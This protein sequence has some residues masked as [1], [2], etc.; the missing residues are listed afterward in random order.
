MSG[1]IF[2]FTPKK[3]KPYKIVDNNYGYEQVAHH[4][5]TEHGTVVVERKIG[6]SKVMVS[7]TDPTVEHGKFSVSHNAKKSIN[8]VYLQ[9]IG[10]DEP[11]SVRSAKEG[12]TTLALTWRGMLH[13]FFIR[14][15]DVARES[16]SLLAPDG[17][18]PTASEA[19]LLYLLT[20]Q[21]ADDLKAEE[22]PA[23]GEARKKALVTY[24][25]EKLVAVDKRREGLETALAQKSVPNVQAGVASVR[26]AIDDLQKQI[27]TASA[28]SRQ[29]MSQ[30]YAYN[31]KLSESQTIGENFAVL[32][33]QYQADIRRI[34][35]IVDGASNV[36]LTK[37]KVMP[38]LRQRIRPC[39]GHVVHKRFRSRA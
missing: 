11:H 18:G 4:L 6:D 1:L 16:S 34:G 36:P 19:T 38:Y 15:R 17:V 24:I 35:F 10:I 27:D 30:I 26:K 32:R 3:N 22:D 2:G 29:L 13:L 23:I 21:D 25:K 39:S 20:G 5:V 14:Q 12:S 9:L 28:E 7:G 8:S 37:H 33:K 31:S